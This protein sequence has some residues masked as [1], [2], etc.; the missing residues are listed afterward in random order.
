M[1][2][3]RYRPPHFR[4]RQASSNG[5]SRGERDA[6]AAA[7][8]RSGG[9]SLAE[10]AS[11]PRSEREP[12]TAGRGEARLEH[13][14]TDCDGRCAFEQ[15]RRQGSLQA[16]LRE[17]SLFPGEP[18]TVRAHPAG[19]ALL[20]DASDFCACFF[21]VEA[22]LEAGVQTACLNGE[23]SAAECARK[24][25]TCIA[26]LLAA[27][28]SAAPLYVSR[29]T[30]CFRGSSRTNVHAEQFM[31][32]DGELLAALRSAG[33]AG[34]CLQLFLTYQP[35][36]HS[37]GHDRAASVGEASHSAS[38][39][40]ALLRFREREL[41]PASVSLEIL[42]PNLYRAHWVHFATEADR[43]LYRPRIAAAQAGLLLLASAPQTSV[44][45]VGDAEW[46]FLLALTRDGRL[47][48][49]WGDSA[50]PRSGPFTEARRLARGKMDAFVSALLE[51]MAQHVAAE[52]AAAS[53]QVDAARPD[54]LGVPARLDNE[55]TW[56]AEKL[57]SIFG[58]LDLSGC[59]S[60]VAPVPRSLGAADAELV[61]CQPAMS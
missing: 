49:Q 61:F 25:V 29:Y 52:S 48:A 55:K 19:V 33:A 13:E 2:T 6:E 21:H 34:G 53:A 31:M 1:A 14:R 43:Q 3:Q 18:H 8:A 23:G 9:R 17:R 10:L 54:A 42:F 22:C 51:R 30:N 28:R 46:A 4:S 39:T 7:P 26:R 58:A 56:S 45:A 20:G 15:Q 41:A 50:G 47:A 27:D 32:R 24:S 57:G 37:S 44:R 59:P 40:T 36:H 60:K 16:V 12:W 35:C 11:G 38:C 5:E